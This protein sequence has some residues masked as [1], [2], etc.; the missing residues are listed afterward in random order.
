MTN[1]LDVFF[2][3]FESDDLVLELK[4]MEAS[5]RMFER[6]VVKQADVVKL[7]LDVTPTKAQTK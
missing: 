2:S 3:R 1:E 7:F 6:V 4:Q 5:L